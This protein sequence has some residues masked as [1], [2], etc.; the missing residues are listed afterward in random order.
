MA[1]GWV[2]GAATL[3]APVAMTF[4]IRNVTGARLLERTM[5]QRPGWEEYAAR[6]PMFFP[7]PPRRTPSSS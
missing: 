4:F 6:T 5:S 1:T 7:R 3:V 2:P